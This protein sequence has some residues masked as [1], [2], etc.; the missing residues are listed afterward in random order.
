MKKIDFH[1]F[2]HVDK[3]AS[4][5]HLYLK[6]RLPL[7]EARRAAKTDL[8]MDSLPASLEATRAS[9]EDCADVPALP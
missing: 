4:L 8:Q 9:G 5:T 7:A 3:L 6:L 1:Q 2:S